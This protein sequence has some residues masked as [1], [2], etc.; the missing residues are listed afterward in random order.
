[1]EYRFT[2][3]SHDRYTPKGIDALNAELDLRLNG[4]EVG[5]DDWH[6]AAKAFHDEVR[7]SEVDDDDEGELADKLQD[8]IDWAWVDAGYGHR[9]IALPLRGLI[10]LFI[11]GELT[12]GRPPSQKVIGILVRGLPLD[13]DGDKS[14]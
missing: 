7:R 13:I 4:L 1:M 6:A 14:E 8:V 2:E 12:D 3:E 11:S 9:G 5:S 10:D